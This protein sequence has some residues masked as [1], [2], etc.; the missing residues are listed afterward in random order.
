MPINPHEKGKKSYYKFGKLVDMWSNQ[1]TTIVS[2]NT[3][4]KSY[5]TINC[6]RLISSD[7]NRFS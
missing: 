5:L 3:K 6:L 2:G 4:C 1:V 7:A